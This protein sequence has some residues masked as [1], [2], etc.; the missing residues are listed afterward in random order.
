MTGRNA[1]LAR[2]RATGLA[3]ALAVAFAT[4]ARAIEPLRVDPDVTAYHK[5]GALY[6]QPS[7]SLRDVG[8]D[9]NLFLTSP[10]APASS[11]L[12]YTIAPQAR[13]FA[14]AGRRATV[15]ATGNLSYTSYDRHSEESFFAGGGSG[16]GDYYLA[17]WDLYAG[18][19][20]MTTRVRPTDDTHLRPRR[21]D[22]SLT[23]GARL[24]RAERLSL[25]LYGLEDDTAY[26]EDDPAGTFNF[27][28]R[29]N[30]KE[31]AAGAA[32]A[33]RVGRK[34]DLAVEA[35]ARDYDF[36]DG[37]ALTPL[38]RSRKVAAGLDWQPGGR[39]STRLR[40]GAMRFD[41]EDL[42][43][44]SF[45]GAV[46]S[47]TAYVRLFPRLAVSLSG[48][49]DV[50]LSAF[51]NDLFGLA[52]RGAI[53][54]T[55]PL[56]RKVGAEL[57]GEYYRARYSDRAALPVARRDHVS[58]VYAGG[59]YRFSDQTSVALRVTHFLRNSNLDDQDSEENLASASMEWLF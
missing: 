7:L 30:R 14:G 15:L 51:E 52:T 9:D 12:T 34:T 48:G 19:D 47:A 10:S 28:E 54:F 24:V 25:N 50:W 36:T 33:Y 45:D 58:R 5:L 18:T 11:D 37:A 56:T 40:A 46:W 41:P 27:R 57:G 1:A 31:R 13:L 38:V 39:I 16:R 2:A 4:E 59:R 32:L 26:R 8:Y 35:E 6:W 55:S 20:Y 3:M 17:H 43:G 42:P 23:F 21:V 49:R 44:Q 22:Q 29:L 53:A